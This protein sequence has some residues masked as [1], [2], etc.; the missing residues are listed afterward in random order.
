[1]DRNLM[2]NMLSSKEESDCALGKGL[3][4]NN[5]ELGL[6]DAE[7]LVSVLEELWFKMGVK[8]QT[9]RDKYFEIN[10]IITDNLMNLSYKKSD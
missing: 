8:D 4:K 6:L 9:S 5:M 2:L 3:L 10:R 7:G 1:M